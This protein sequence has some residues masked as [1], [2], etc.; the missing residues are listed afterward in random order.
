MIDLRKYQEKKFLRGYRIL[1]NGSI[2]RGLKR[3]NPSNAPRVSI[4]GTDYNMAVLFYTTF[5]SNKRSG[6]YVRRIDK[7]KNYSVCN[8]IS[9]PK[10][11]DH[12][13]VVKFFR[14]Y[15]IKLNA[16]R[17]YFG[18]QHQI[19]KLREEVRELDEAIK[20]HDVEAII[21]EL[22]DVF[23]VGLQILLYFGINKSLELFNKKLSRTLERIGS[24]YY[25]NEV[26]R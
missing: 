1:A 8:L 20:K 10:N 11:G 22:I 21:E 7:T 9:Y 18:I 16:V 3:L 25:E 4:L 2:M 12:T 19:R 15:A 13:I 14:P 6:W 5:I 17:K 23:L 26:L 24:G